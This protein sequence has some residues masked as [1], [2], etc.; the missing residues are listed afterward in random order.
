[1]DFFFLRVAGIQLRARRVKTAF[2]GDISPWLGQKQQ[3]ESLVFIYSVGQAR[4]GR[5]RGG[6][7][8]RLDCIPGHGP[9]WS[10]VFHQ[11]PL[12]SPAQQPPART[13]GGVLCL[14][15]VPSPAEGKGDAAKWGKHVS[16]SHIIEYRSPGTHASPGLLRVSAASPLFPLCWVCGQREML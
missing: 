15:G 9:V 6:A 3:S 14:L 11:R 16:D 7:G 5:G 10:S 4:V 12:S 13:T 2:R 8:G 1:M